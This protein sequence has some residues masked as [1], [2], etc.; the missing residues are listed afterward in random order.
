MRIYEDEV[1]FL[2]AYTAMYAFAVCEFFEI[3]AKYIFMRQ[4]M[5]RILVQKFHE[6]RLRIS[7]I[8]VLDNYLRFR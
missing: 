7:L 5:T 3:E 8:A 1:K 6:E 2:F 4:R